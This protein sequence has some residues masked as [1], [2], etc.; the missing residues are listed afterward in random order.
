MQIDEGGAE[1]LDLQ[2]TLL[3][4]ISQ[5]TA[6]AEPLLAP[7]QHNRPVVLHALRLADGPLYLVHALDAELVVHLRPLDPDVPHTLK[8]LNP[9]LRILFHNNQQS[10]Q[11]K[12]PRT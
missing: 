7:G 4:E 6:G 10:F 12:K 11:R 2:N 5:F 8:I 3:A 9:N 1:L